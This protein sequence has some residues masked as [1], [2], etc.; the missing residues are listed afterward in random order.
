MYI[1]LE[2]SETFLGEVVIDMVNGFYQAPI[3]A[4]IR[5][6]LFSYTTDIHVY[7]ALLIHIGNGPSQTSEILLQYGIK[8]QSNKSINM[9]I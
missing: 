9:Y 3:L 1:A 7:L 8:H 5:L 6:L 2:K 4:R